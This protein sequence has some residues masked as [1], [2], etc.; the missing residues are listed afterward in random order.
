MSRNRGRTGGGTETKKP[1]NTG[2]PVQQLADEAPETAAFSFVVPTEFV[3][4][5]SKGRYYSEVH[6]L[7]NQET[8]EIKQMTAKEEDIL[9]SR[10]LLKK[11]IALDRVM[12]SLICNKAI[13]PNSLLLGDKN[14]LIVSIRSTSYGNIYT[15]QVEC[16]SCGASQEH[17]FDLNELQPYAGRK[18]EGLN[19]AENDD[20]TFTTILPR[21]GAEVAFKLLTGHDERKM[22][23]LAETDKKARRSRNVTRQ[24]ETTIVSV[25]GSTDLENIRYV[26]ENMPSADTRHL[27]TV[28]RLAMPDLDM[29][30]DFVC[31]ECDY[32]EDMEVPLSVDFFWPQ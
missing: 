24:L 30:Q 20:G 19:V 6:P 2:A 26:V 31:S 25:N 12:Q 28:Y 11:G 14:A 21:S 1:D 22:A 29:T 16:P 10:T 27:R 15:T 18:F 3:E 17:S 32:S 7:R 8:I 9:T 4:L 13:D 5:P 23:N